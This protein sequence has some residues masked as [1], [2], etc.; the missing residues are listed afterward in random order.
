MHHT[1]TSSMARTDQ[2][3]TDAVQLTNSR[4]FS[5]D[6]HGLSQQELPVNSNIHDIEGITVSF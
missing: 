1:S 4:L 6:V 3:L 2:I 5:C